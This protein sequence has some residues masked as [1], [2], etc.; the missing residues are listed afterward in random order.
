MSI[1]STPIEYLKG[2]GPARAALLKKEL[3]IFTYQD[4]TSYY[5]FRYIDKSKI[6]KINEIVDNMPFIQL[7][8]T[9]THFSELS[10]IHI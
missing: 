3:N 5:P 8:G 7:K 2:V 6:H 1:L 4:L 10:L 9:I